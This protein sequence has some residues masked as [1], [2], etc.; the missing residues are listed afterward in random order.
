ML[1]WIFSTPVYAVD[2]L[3][4]LTNYTTCLTTNGDYVNTWLQV[5]VTELPTCVDSCPTGPG[6]TTAFNK[7]CAR[8]NDYASS[9]K[10]GFT[11]HWQ[12][13]SLSDASVLGCEF[14]SDPH[15]PIVITASEYRFV[16]EAKIEL[17]LNIPD[18]NVHCSSL[19]W[20]RDPSLWV[21]E[22]LYMVRVDE[23]GPGRRLSQD[24][25][26][27]TASAEARQLALSTNPFEVYFSCRVDTTR[28]SSSSSVVSSFAGNDPSSLSSALGWQV[29]F[30]QP[31]TLTSALDP[32]VDQ[33]SDTSYAMNYK[34]ACCAWNS[35]VTTTTPVPTSSF[36]SSAS[37]A[38]TLSVST[39]RSSSS[40]SSSSHSY[41]SS[42]TQ[43]VSTTSTTN[44]PLAIVNT[45]SSLKAGIITGGALGALVFV[46]MIFIMC[47][48]K[49]REPNESVRSEAWS[50][51]RH[52][53]SAKPSFIGVSPPGSESDEFSPWEEDSPFSRF[54]KFSAN[55][56]TYRKQHEEREKFRKIQRERELNERKQREVNKAKASAWEEEFL[57]SQKPYPSLPSSA[58]GDVDQTIDTFLNDLIEELQTAKS[59]P[60]DK[61]KKIY[62]NLTLKWHPDKQA[63]N[64][65]IA[66]QVFQLLRDK[67]QWF[68]N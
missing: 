55:Q 13:S 57:R 64:E 18:K 56:A 32:L 61:R 49:R 66:N 12:C 30:F 5:P 60:I 20:Q 4:Q 10:L 2:W 3:A 68:L 23:S 39:S 7:Y 31:P 52:R 59:L 41:S 33:W 24:D 16:I 53:K 58:D 38:S 1:W 27:M 17:M 25:T 48:R 9:L 8:S 47:R 45:N 19:F 51:P 28:L 35:L 63:G 21:L 22:D 42:I 54:D 6:K 29:S 26:I 14:S 44:A 34:F 37:T 36:S 62:R 43:S 46:L 67:K 40:S 11:F 50:V 65:T 15:D